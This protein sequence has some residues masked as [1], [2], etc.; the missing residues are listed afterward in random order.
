M[1]W[2]IL[3]I[4]YGIFNIISLYYICRASL[5]D[6]YNEGWIIDEYKE[7][8]EEYNVIGSLIPTIFKIIL[9]LPSL[10]VFYILKILAGEFPA[11]I[12]IIWKEIFGRKDK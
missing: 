8:R 10:T 6:N 11:F 1:I 7:L 5:D 4:L 9:W 12:I 3:L 2:I